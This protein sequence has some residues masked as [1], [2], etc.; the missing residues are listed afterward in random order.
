M[1]VMHSYCNNSCRCCS[2]IKNIIRN[3]Y[4]K[5]MILEAELEDLKCLHE[6]MDYSSDTYQF[7]GMIGF[8][9]EVVIDD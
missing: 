9:K 4:E 6:S 7:S 5:I 2:Y 8:P 3:T 1:S